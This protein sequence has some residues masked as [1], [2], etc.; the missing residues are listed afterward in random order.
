MSH[1]EKRQT[2]I[3]TERSKNHLPN[4]EYMHERS[5][6]AGKKLP[7]YL[8]RKNLH[9]TSENTVLGINSLPPLTDK[10]I[11]NAF[12]SDEMLFILSNGNRS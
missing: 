11:Q 3:T 6:L 9:V 5:L 7:I 10:Q 12:Y 1:S 4:S 8:W 2:K